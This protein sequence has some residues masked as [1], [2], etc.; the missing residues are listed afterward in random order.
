MHTLTSSYSVQ[1]AP[2]NGAEV[3]P[4]ASQIG[5]GNPL[6]QRG[7]SIAPTL[8]RHGWISFQGGSGRGRHGPA[9]TLTG[10]LLEGI[11]G[12]ESHR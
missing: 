1:V 8:A 11:Q 10:D 6:I 4:P 5:L 7:Q 2:L 12:A 3:N 9:S